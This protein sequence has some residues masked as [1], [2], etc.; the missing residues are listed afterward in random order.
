[1]AD[2]TGAVLEIGIG[3]FSTPA[4]H[5]FCLASGRTLWSLESDGLWYETFRGKYKHDLHKFLNGDYR[6]IL[7]GKKLRNYYAPWSVT[8]IDSWPSSLPHA[9]T[10]ASRRRQDFESMIDHSDFVLV[11]DYEHETVAA[12]SPLL[13]TVP[14]A[15]V[16][17]AYEPPTLI[18]SMV[19]KIPES[20]K[21]L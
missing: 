18:A 6:E 1:L 21:I 19:R 4:L 13:A 10:V 8:L 17:R 15:H 2:T 11:H 16:T 9:S 5:A 3:H 14:H 12:I 7:E 20:V